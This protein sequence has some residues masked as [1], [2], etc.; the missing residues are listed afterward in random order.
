MGT[1]MQVQIQGL[2]GGWYGIKECNPYLLPIEGV[3]IYIY[4]CTRIRYIPLFPTNPHREERTHGSDQVG[5]RAT[6]TEHPAA[7]LVATD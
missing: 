2:T 6:T 7:N 3:Y 5:L 4:I 1:D